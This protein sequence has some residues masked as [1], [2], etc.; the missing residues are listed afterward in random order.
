MLNTSEIRQAYFDHFI[1]RHHVLVP[2]ASLVPHEDPTTLFTGSGMQPL[3]PYLLGQPHPAG[4]RLVDSQPCFRAEDI[5]VVGDS[6]HTTFF[7]MLGNWSLGAYF[8][9]E[10][11]PA[12]FSFLTEVLGLD[13][14]LLYPTA[15]SGA[16]R[17]GIPRDDEAISIWKELFSAAGLA[18]STAVLETSEHAS[19]VGLGTSRISLYNEDYCW[20]SRSGPPETMPI[21]EP[22]GP[23]S[24]VFYL[25]EQVEHDTAFGDQCHPH[26]DCGRFI[27]IGNSVFMQYRRT[28][29]G[30]E[31][32]PQR[33]VD[34]GGGLERLAMAVLDSLRGTAAAAADH[35]RSRPGARLPGGR[36]SGS[37]EHCPGLR[38]AA[39]RPPR[40]A[41]GPRHRHHRQSLERPRRA[42]RRL[43]WG[44]L[45]R[46]RRPHR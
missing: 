24:E 23:D 35:R 44:C 21:G 26:C 42:C 30:F 4:E 19:S 29:D 45:S 27:E 9:A 12:F 38:D 31:E 15:L 34:F 41:P 11:L 10:Q 17:Y 36:R 39:L 14:A 25:F 5:D 40:H 3:I 20:W 37:V 33:N 6:R 18:T 28:E 32:L 2:R 46:A 7:E 43:L 16:P 1:A 13:P 22:G 8:K